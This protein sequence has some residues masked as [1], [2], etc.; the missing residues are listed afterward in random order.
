MNHNEP[1]ESAVTPHDLLPTEAAVDRL[2]ESERAGAS[3]TL[4]RRV[5]EATWPLLAPPLG[6]LEEPRAHQ[7]R[8]SRLRLLTPLR[9]AAGLALM[10]AVGAT[11]LA[12]WRPDAS[13]AM[14][15]ID[16][17]SGFDVHVE[18]LL[19]WDRAASV[20][21][22]IDQLY[23]ELSLLD[24]LMGDDWAAESLAFDGGSL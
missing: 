15:R 10:A 14:A 18:S 1:H 2:A 24:P 22:R 12:G 8:T 23:V 5:H 21:S 19:A 6:V 20:A 9:A 16:G 4:V 7:I 13:Q 11:W 3:P 17:L